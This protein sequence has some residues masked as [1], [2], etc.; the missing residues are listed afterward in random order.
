M[1]SLIF[2]A[3]K[4]TYITNSFINPNVSAFINEDITSVR[5]AFEEV[6]VPTKRLSH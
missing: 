2:N 4:A 3:V 6:S 1:I 5:Q